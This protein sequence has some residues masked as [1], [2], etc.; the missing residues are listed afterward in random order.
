M[1]S[2][3]A[4]GSLPGFTVTDVLMDVDGTMTYVRKKTDQTANPTRS[5]WLSLW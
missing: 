1:V 4:P 2:T 3:P 5:Y